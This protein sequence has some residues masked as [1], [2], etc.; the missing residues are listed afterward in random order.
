[1]SCHNTTS[2]R[3]VMPDPLVDS[4]RILVA[5]V[6]SVPRPLIDHGPYTGYPSSYDCQNGLYFKPWARISP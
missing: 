3:H 5:A 1:M 6:C 4:K 2:C